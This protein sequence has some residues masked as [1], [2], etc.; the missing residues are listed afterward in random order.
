[1]SEEV[2]GLSGPGAGVQVSEVV[3]ASNKTGIGGTRI[4]G[5]E[6]G[7]TISCSLGCL[8]IRLVLL[9]G[10]RVVDGLRQVTP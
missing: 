4:M 6:A 8:R 9:V 1:V 10:L 7:V 5:A 3:T 2:V